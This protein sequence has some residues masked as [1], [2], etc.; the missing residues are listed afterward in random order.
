MVNY[1]VSLFLEPVINRVEDRNVTKFRS[2]FS[3]LFSKDDNLSKIEWHKLCRLVQW[4]DIYG[5]PQ[6]IASAAFVTR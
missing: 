1:V 6:Y 3:N 5:Y 4:N 2:M